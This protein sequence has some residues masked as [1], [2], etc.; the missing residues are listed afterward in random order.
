MLRVFS[1]QV[2]VLSQEKRCDLRCDIMKRRLCEDLMET[3]QNWPSTFYID[4]FY[5]RVISV[6]KKSVRLPIKG[7]RPTLVKGI[8]F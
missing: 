1:R 4:P 6:W 8:D 7:G 2:H 5:T 3:S